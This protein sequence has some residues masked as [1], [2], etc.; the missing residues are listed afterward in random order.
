VK[1]TQWPEGTII[2]KSDGKKVI[3]MIMRNGKF[4]DYTEGES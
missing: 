4:V 1:T 3:R 2:K